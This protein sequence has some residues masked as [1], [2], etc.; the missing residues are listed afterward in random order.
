MHRRFT[1]ATECPFVTRDLTVN[2]Y[3]QPGAIANTNTPDDGGSNAVLKIELSEPGV[4][5]QTAGLR[6]TNGSGALTVRGLAINRF[7]VNLSLDAAATHRVEGCFIGTDITGMATSDTSNGSGFGIRS[8]GP[9]II[10]GATAAKRDVIAGS[11][12][13]AIYVFA[14][15]TG[16][17]PQPLRVLGN[18]IGTDI[19]GTSPIGNG[20]NPQLPSQPQPTIVAFGSGRCGL[21]IGGDATGE[22]NL[23]GNGGAAGVLVSTCSDARILGNR[24]VRNGGIGIDLAVSRNADGRTPNDPGDADGNPP[25]AAGNRL[26][27]HPEIISL[28][29]AAMTC[30]LTYRVDTDLANATYPLRIDV[31]RGRYGQAEFP[32][33]VDTYTAVDASQPKTVTFALAALQGGGA[34]VLSA[35]DAAGNTSKFGGNHLFEDDFD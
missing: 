15:V 19:T 30:T 12:F 27:N 5:S 28:A 1:P 7:Q 23:I 18:Y 33:V 13:S 11:T 26:Q 35:T 14:Q 10:G 16:V 6:A 3:S 34:L 17:N 31:A 8:G 9:A 25:F 4:G 24:F 32:V 21:A 2:G 20:L 22:G 29:C